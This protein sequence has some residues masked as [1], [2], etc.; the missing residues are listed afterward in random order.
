MNKFVK[1][2][3]CVSI[4]CTL[5]NAHALDGKLSQIDYVMNLSYNTAEYWLIWM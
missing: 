2:Y 1:Q 4:R 3:V 5:S